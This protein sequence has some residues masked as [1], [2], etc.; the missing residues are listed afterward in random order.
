MIDVS[1]TVTC[2]A[3]AVAMTCLA[4]LAAGFVVREAVRLVR[5]RG[6]R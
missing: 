3:C 1:V 4:V 5:N 2:V 6:Q